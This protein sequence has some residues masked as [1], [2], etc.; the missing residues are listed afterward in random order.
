MHVF[1]HSF[2]NTF[3]Y[4]ETYRRNPCSNTVDFSSLKDIDE[5]C[6][7]DYCNW[8]QML[9]M[10][11]DEFSRS[12]SSGFQLIHPTPQKASFYTNLY[13]NSR[14][15]DQMLAKW[16]EM[17][18]LRG[19]AMSFLPAS[20]RS[21]FPKQSIRRSE[22]ESGEQKKQIFPQRPKSANPSRPGTSPYEVSLRRPTSAT[23]LR[24]KA[25]GASNFLSLKE[26]LTDHS[27]PFKGPQGHDTNHLKEYT[28]VNINTTPRI[29]LESQSE[30]NPG[31]IKKDHADWNLISRINRNIVIQG[32]NHTN[33][34]ALEV[35]PTL[36]PPKSDIQ[37]FMTDPQIFSST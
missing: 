28:S 29:V 37:R 36:P 11:E 33:D 14:F 7:Y 23:K 3:V 32:S 10:I 35:H 30:K 5:M 2:T 22:F 17:G 6:G 12:K 21:N 13:R 20:V 4:I 24:T 18:G 1:C 27:N 15:S 25:A 8:W 31:S 16:V 26:Y 19:R 9:L 34:S